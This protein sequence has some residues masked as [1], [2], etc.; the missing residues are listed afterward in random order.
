MKYVIN[1]AKTP[2]VKKRRG[3]AFNTILISSKG[4]FIKTDTDAMDLIARNELKL[5]N[6][7]I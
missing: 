1:A 3:N 7:T 5:H 2:V 4:L 6:L